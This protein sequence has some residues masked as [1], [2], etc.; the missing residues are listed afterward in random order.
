MKKIIFTLTV[1]CLFSCTTDSGNNQKDIIKQE[2][3]VRTKFLYLEPHIKKIHGTGMIKSS[4][5][6]NLMFEVPGKVNV[7]NFSIGEYV[8]KGDIIASLKKDVYEAKF[9]LAEA[10][11]KKANRDSDNIANLYNNKAVSEDQYLLAK[12][13]QKNAQSDFITAQNAYES[14]EILAPFD[15]TITHINLQ[16]GE[17]FSPGPM[18]MPPVILSN[19]D[20]LQL[21]ANIA[22]KEIVSISKGQEAIITNS[23][24]NLNEGLKGI[25]SEV[26]FVPTT[27]SNSY[28]VEIDLI[29][30]KD[31]LKLGMVVNFSVNVSE[32]KK[33]FMLSNRY[34]LKEKDLYYIWSVKN[35]KPEKIYVKVNGM[36]NH[37]MIIDGDFPSGIEII[38]DGGRQVD[39]E[40]IIR[41][42]K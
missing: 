34:I 40:S 32:L 18:P 30:K 7:V 19:M 24:E 41:V 17:S 8:Q 26:G 4:Q 42:V 29:E 20:Q 15:G 1:L 39:E 22:S 3:P 33:V 31:Y 10:A 37:K 6:V 2:I 5:Q 36:T 28:K 16:V 27:M 13:G 21:E 11:L 12:L 35:N 23:F 38:T 9:L 14:T 25:V